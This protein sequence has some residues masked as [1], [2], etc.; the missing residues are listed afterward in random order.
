MGRDVMDVGIGLHTQGTATGGTVRV[1]VMWAGIHTGPSGPEHECSDAIPVAEVKAAC[2]AARTAVDAG[3]PVADVIAAF[4]GK[5][6][7]AA[8]TWYD[9]KLPNDTWRHAMALDGAAWESD[10]YAW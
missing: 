3:D 1:C 7:A 9:T 8:A 4:R 6:P 10:G 5:L 2:K